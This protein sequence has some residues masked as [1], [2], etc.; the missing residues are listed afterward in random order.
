VEPIERLFSPTPSNVGTARHFVI[1]TLRQG[2]L[3]AFPADVAVSE[4]AANVVRHARTDFT[5]R[6][7][8]AGPEVR[9]EVSDRDPVIPVMSDPGEEREGGYGLL[10]IERLTRSWGVEQGPHGKTIWFTVAAVEDQ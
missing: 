1:D 6:I 5:V 8:P 10:L 7:Q 3:Q 4:L 2:G 9:I